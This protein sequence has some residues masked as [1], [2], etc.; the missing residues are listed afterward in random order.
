MFNPDT[1]RL[2]HSI[3]HDRDHIGTIVLVS[4]LGGMY[5]RIRKSFLV[6]AVIF[7]LCLIISQLLARS[8]VR[9]ISQPITSLVTTSQK[10]SQTGDYSIRAQKFHEDN[11]GH[12]TDLF[13]EM[14]DQIE[15]REQMLHEEQAALRESQERE[16]KLKEQLARSE[17]LESLGLLAGG[18]AHDLN[19]ILGPLVGYPDLVLDQLCPPTRRFVMTCTRCSRLPTR[20]RMSFKTC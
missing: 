6:V 18:V 11:F 1:V 8:F 3:I 20:R 16:A 2:T 4:D 7:T 13:N 14:L 5:D 19:N 10:V 12:L 17:G 15:S 9:I